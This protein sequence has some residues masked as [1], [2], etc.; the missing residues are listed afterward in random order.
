MNYFAGIGAR[1]TPPNI[2][3]FMKVLARHLVTNGW[4]LRSGGALGAD[5]AF[6]AGAWEAIA[7]DPFLAKPEIFTAA[8]CTVAA[9]A[10]ASQYHP[11]WPACKPYVRQLHGRNAQIMLGR[12]VTEPVPANVVLCWTPGGA[13]YGGT[14]QSI[15][16]ANGLEIPVINI[17]R[18][19]F[20]S[21]YSMLNFLDEVTIPYV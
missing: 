20:S 16:M 3:V 13:V 7:E 9:Q 15:R 12:D 5:T 21:V 8:D 4:T 6:E 14:G 10:I 11:N 19:G 17:A 1:S 2:L 18:E